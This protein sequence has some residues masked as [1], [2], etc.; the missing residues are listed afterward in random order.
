MKHWFLAL[1]IALT[2][3]S[4]YSS[5]WSPFIN[6]YTCIYQPCCRPDA[7]H[8]NPLNL[9]VEIEVDDVGSLDS[10]QTIF[11][12]SEVETATVIY[13]LGKG[14]PQIEPLEIRIGSA[15]VIAMKADI[16]TQI[17]GGLT[18]GVSA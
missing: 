12:R 3:C 2:S 10:T 9:V 7:W 14:R 17:L 15:H 6:E 16:S 4:T 5:K 11:V 18:I 8:I 13:G 1:A